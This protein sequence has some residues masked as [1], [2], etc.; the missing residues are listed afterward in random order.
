MAKNKKPAPQPE[1]PAEEFDTT[2]ELT[3]EE[4]NSTVFEMLDAFSFGNR[5]YAVLLSAAEPDKGVV[6]LESVETED[7]AESYIGIGDEETVNAVFEEFKERNK[8][9]FEF[10][11]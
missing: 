5:E 11:D 1:L 3:D 8:D 4:G 2:I 9:L 6:I 7:G 10:V